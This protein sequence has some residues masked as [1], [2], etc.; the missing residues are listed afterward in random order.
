MRPSRGLDCPPFAVVGVQFLGDAQRD[1]TRLSRQQLDNFDAVIDAARGVDARAQTK[2]HLPGSNS[3][4]WNARD[5]F[6]R[7][8]SRSGR[9]AQLDKTA[10]Q[11]RA[12]DAR[13]RHH[14]GN[15]AKRDNIEIAPE[16]GH[17]A[18]KP[19]LVAQFSAQTND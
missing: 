17:R 4:V 15:R 7:D 16:V 5:L 14:V 6:E 3:A 19:T 18:L 13:E 12:I 2:A 11:Q 9:R 1:F 10:A 8:D